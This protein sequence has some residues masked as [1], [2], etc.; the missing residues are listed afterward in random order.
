M[1]D[2]VTSWRGFR[3]YPSRAHDGDS[4]WVMAD[5]GFG[6]RHEPEL[7]LYDVGAPELVMRLPRLFQPGGQETTEFVAEWMRQAAASQPGRRWFLS[8]GVGMTKTYEPNEKTTFRRY[9]A[10]VF[11]YDE[12]P[13]PWATPPP[14][15]RLSLNYAVR[16]YVAE[17]GW[18]T[19]D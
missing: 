16:L 13:M 11:R 1:P 14:D 12:W 2:R 7:R 4:F 3:A 10:T 8:V 9:V 17:N 15:D 6:D 5:T 18:P 19:G